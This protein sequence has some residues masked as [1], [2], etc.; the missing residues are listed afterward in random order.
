[1]FQGTADGR[2]VAYDAANG[3]KKWE[4]PAGTG[5]IAAPATYTVKGRQYVSVL[6][7]WGGAYALIGRRSAK[8]GGVPGRLLTFALDGKAALPAAPPEAPAPAPIAIEADPGKVQNGA[9]L[10]ARWCSV[11]RWKGPTPPRACRR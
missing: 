5:I 11:C 6:A 8:N 7:G 1:M 9:A 2:F 4:M 3:E 10:Y